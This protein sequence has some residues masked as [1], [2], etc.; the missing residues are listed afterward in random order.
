MEQKGPKLGWLLGGLGGLIWLPILAGVWVAQGKAA[1]AA[2]AGIVFAVGVLYLLVLPPWRFPQT[3][4][5]LLYLG[6][7]IIA[8]AGV[9]IA[10]WQY[11]DPRTFKPS[12]C[13]PGIVLVTLLIPLFTLGR[14]TWS[15]LHG[16]ATPP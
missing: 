7:L 14:K 12:D 15:D 1:G 11:Y 4:L 5:R 8:L 13:T 2:G 9:A 3:P 6:L 16:R 10:A